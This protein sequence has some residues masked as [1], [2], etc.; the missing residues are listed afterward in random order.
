MVIATSG[1]NYINYNRIISSS[2]SP[3]HVLNFQTFRDTTSST[4]RILSA[5]YI[6][7]QN[8]AVSL[9]YDT[10][11]GYTDLAKINFLTPSISLLKSISNYL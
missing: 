6:I 10:S 8:N 7:D 9:I 2:S 11:T 5:L 1:Y 3:Y 4:F